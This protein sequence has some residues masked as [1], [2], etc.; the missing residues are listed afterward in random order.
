MKLRR[1]HLRGGPEHGEFIKV[2]K[3]V[4]VY[5]TG[6]GPRGCYNETKETINGNVVFV[7]EKEF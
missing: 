5:F 1:V 7:W 4:H 3:D 2:G 6:E